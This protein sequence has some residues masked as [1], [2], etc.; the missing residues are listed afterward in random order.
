MSLKAPRAT[1]SARPVSALTQ[2][3]NPKQVQDPPQERV[4][5]VL[6]QIR[7]DRV[8]RVSERIR[9]ADRPDHNRELYR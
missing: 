4:N 7:A 8:L 3:G 5:R 1:G 9:T 6:G 2:C